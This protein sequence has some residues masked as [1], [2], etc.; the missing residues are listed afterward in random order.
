M[1][2]LELSGCGTALI[3]PFRA[4]GSVDENTLHSLV[5]WQVENGIRLLVVAGS[6]GEAST[7]S[8][9]ELLLVARMSISTAAG[10]AKVFVGCTHNAT[11]EAV[12]RAKRIAKLSGVTGILTAC[13]YYNKPSQEGMYLHFQAIAQAVSPLPVLLYNVPGR[14]ASNLLPET[15]LRLSAIANIVGIKESSGN[16]TQIAELLTTLPRDFHVFCGDDAYALPTIA[17]GAVGLISVAS[18]AAPAL[19][20]EMVEAALRNDWPVARRIQRQT[21]R[22]VRELFLEP[23]PG[24]IKAVLSAMG[25]IEE[26]YLRLPMTP[27]TFPMRRRLESTAGELGLLVDAPPSGED[28]RMF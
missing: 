5:H 12:K 25:K 1:E 24:P 6:T 7:L 10:R 16:M 22:L 15:V 13:P 19:I 11:A 17:T 28:L 21:A 2:T 14:T 23:N 26:D 4:D 20:G 8:D 27:V 18:N 3:T 9:E